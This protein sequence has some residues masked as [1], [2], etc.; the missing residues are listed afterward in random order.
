MLNLI[1]QVIAPLVLCTGR[2][3]TSTHLRGGPYAPA[4]D[5]PLPPARGGAERRDAC[6]GDVRAVG[7]ASGFRRVR[8]VTNVSRRLSRSGHG[9]VVMVGGSATRPCTPHHTATQ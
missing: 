3:S 1:R 8:R 6:D 2:P 9:N 7:M 4:A 5:L